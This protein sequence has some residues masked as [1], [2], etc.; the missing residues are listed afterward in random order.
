MVR[1]NALLSGVLSMGHTLAHDAPRSVFWSWVGTTATV[2][3][4]L[5][6]GQIT[7]WGYGSYFC[8]FRN[9]GCT[10]GFYGGGSRIKEL[11]W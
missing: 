9:Y 1:D 7:A 10:G 5:K 6:T 3:Q 8:W 2:G 11:Y 4:K